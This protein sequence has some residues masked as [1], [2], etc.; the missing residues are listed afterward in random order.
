VKLP[1]FES[2]A[3]T[4]PATAISIAASTQFFIPGPRAAAATDRFR[5]L[6]A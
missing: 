3:L 4:A 6:F 1:E 2:P 5:P